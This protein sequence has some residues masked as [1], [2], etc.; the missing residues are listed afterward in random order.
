MDENRQGSSES[1]IFPLYRAWLCGSFRLERR[2]GLAYVALDTKEWGGH[3]SPRTVLKALICAPRRRASRGTLL[4]QIW[5]EAEGEQASRDLNVAISRLRKILR[6]V[7]GQEC[8]TTEEDSLGFSLAHQSVFWVDADAALARLAVAERIGHQFPEATPL[9]EEALAYFQRGGFLESDEGEWA[10]GKRAMVDRWRDR[11]R[12]WLAEAY[13][14]QGMLGQ[15]EAMLSELL[16]DDPTNEDAIRCL[17]ELF[18]R[19]GLI[20][21]ATAFYQHTSEVFAKEGLELS[22]ATKA[23]ALRLREGRYYPLAGSFVT[24]DRGEPE[25]QRVLQLSEIPVFSSFSPGIL[26]FPSGVIQPEETSLETVSPDCAVQF[27]GVLAQM[28]TLIQQW[29]GMAMFSYN[30]Q[31]QLDRE[32]KKLERFQSHASLE[33]YTLSR[34]SVLFA[35][36]T[37]PTALLTS[38]RQVY[39][40]V[41]EL[42][43]FL[44]QCA[45]SI[46]A[47]WHLSKGNHLETI[48]PII[49]SYLPT[50]L[51]VPKY[52]PLYREMTAD[53]IAQ[54]YLLKSILAWHLENL[55][56]AETY[57]TQAAQYSVIAQN[58]NLRLT[59]LN[60]HALIFYYAK[61]FQRALAASEE[62]Y[63]TLQYLPHESTFSIMKG[64]VS[65]YLAAFQAQQL[66]DGAEQTLEQAQNAFAL[67]GTAGESI[68]PYVDCGEASLTLWDGLTHYHLGVQDVT[69]ARRALTSLKAF[70][71]LQSNTE[72]P[73]RFR[74][75]CLSNR[76]LAAI[77]ANEMEEAINCFAAGRQGASFL[78]SKQ[79]NAEMA[80]ACQELAKQWPGEEKIQKL[81]MVYTK[82]VEQ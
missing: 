80:Y 39:R 16:R 54:C 53:L 40:L 23:C 52:A 27:G 38:R 19:H 41:L 46:T 22:E 73:E 65:M 9:L 71:Q 69:H 12:L 45:A 78:E 79:R 20:H 31:N 47:C 11:C 68:P 13:G 3:S 25:T 42:E 61:Q 1:G 81:C 34:R 70:G 72:I 5:P 58:S 24:K 59:A 64:R 44:P 29:Y 8:F 32:I 51:A 50:L 56:T 49:D 67:Q 2:E 48:P 18:H 4:A 55:A 77:R 7:E 15:A 14:R 63:T 57:C 33:T 35:L 74:L 37:L 21:Q 36:A 60:Q 6:P 76:I 26:L 17:M 28:V 10:D 62:A 43:E 82:H 75:E 66:K 30:L